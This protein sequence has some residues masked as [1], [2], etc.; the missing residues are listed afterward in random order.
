MA[1]STIQK[2]ILA[3]LERLSPD[4]QAQAASYIR[5]LATSLPRGTSGDELMRFWGTIDAESAQEM[6]RVIDE[7]CGRID[8]DGW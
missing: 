7:G 5:A 3:D 8:S 6:L 4:Q 1:H 2:Q